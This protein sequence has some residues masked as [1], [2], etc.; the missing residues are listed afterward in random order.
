MSTRAGRNTHAWR[1]AAWAGLTAAI[2]MVSGCSGGSD[3]AGVPTAP[4]PAPTSSNT[5]SPAPGPFSVQMAATGGECRAT[6]SDP[7]SCN[8][9]ARPSGGQAPLSFTWTF[10][11][12]EASVTMTGST[13]KPTFGCKFGATNFD[14]NIT[15][16]A[17]Q[18]G[19]GPSATAANN[20]TIVRVPGDC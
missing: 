1:A 10:S 14:V 8:F 6:R 11:T 18:G 9:E 16:R 7:V 19:G 20:Q 5:P 15:L 12:P 17:D 2:V 3:P 4:T 13:V